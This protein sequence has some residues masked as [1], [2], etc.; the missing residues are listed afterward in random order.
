MVEVQFTSYDTDDY[1][2]AKGTPFIIDVVVDD[3]IAAGV[4]PPGPEIISQVPPPPPPGAEGAFGFDYR[5]YVCTSFFVTSVNKAEPRGRVMKVVTGGTE[6]DKSALSRDLIMRSY[7]TQ[8]ANKIY[9]KCPK[10][11]LEDNFSAF[12]IETHD[13][14]ASV[15]LLSRSTTGSTFTVS[16]DASDIKFS[17]DSFSGANFALSDQSYKIVYK[18]KTN[19]K[20]PLASIAASSSAVNLDENTVAGQEVV[21]ITA[22]YED[23]SSDAASDGTFSITSGNDGNHFTMVG[24]KVMTTATAFDFETDTTNITVTV[25][26]SLDSVTKTADFTVTVTNVN[27]VPISI[28]FTAVDDLDTNHEGSVGSFTTSDQDAGDSH[29]YTVVNT[30]DTEH[31]TFEIK[32]N[33]EI[34]IKSDVTLEAQEYT[35][36]ITTED[37]GGLTLSNDT[38]SVTFSEG[39]SGVVTQTITVP[40]ESWDWISFSVEITELA[41]IVIESGSAD[42]D[43]IK[44]KD[45]FATHYGEY[46]VGYGWF[47]AD[48]DADMKIG[49]MFQYKN[50][51]SVDKVIRLTGLVP[52]SFELVIEGPDVW[53]WVG[54]CKLDG[55]VEIAQ[56]F[57]GTSYAGDT[58]IK[59]LTSYVEGEETFTTYYEGYGWFPSAF[60][61]RNGEGY[62]IKNMGSNITINL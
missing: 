14:A 23:E 47:P 61:L 50:L 18:T 49:Q 4:N 38:F 9:Y 55:D 46:G 42:L 7:N 59:K 44:T 60:K 22:T 28:T 20:A 31:A 58:L 37:S 35:F 10:Q 62:Q 21:S 33:N 11:T 27:E 32:E 2:S 41:D 54:F 12:S 24:N 25:Q 39:S 17:L 56:V 40:P 5:N 26:L 51:A 52:S 34:H 16:A 36:K 19:V 1:S 43:I 57:T 29:T 53:S 3:T 13:G 6:H 8:S 15:D 48:I 30:D 45:Y